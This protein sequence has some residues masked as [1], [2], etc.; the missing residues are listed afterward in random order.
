MSHGI[1]AYGSYLPRHRLGERVAAAYDEDATTMAVAAAQAAL[2]DDHRIGHVWLATTSPPYLDK[3]NAA[4][5]HAALAL[6]REVFAADVGGAARSGIAALRAGIAAGGLV[7]LADVRVGLPGSADEKTGGD[8]AAAFVFGEGESIADVVASASATIELLDRW[9][10]PDAVAARTWEE[11]FGAEALSPLV[12]ETAARALADVGLEQADHVVVVSSSAG[13]RRAAGRLLTGRF[14]TSTSPIGHAGA[15]DAGL[16][17]AAV[18]DSAGSDETILLISAADG[19]DALVF[20]TTQ[21]LLSRRQPSPVSAQLPGEPVEY[22]RYLTWRGLLDREPPRR[23]E[24][25]APAGPPAFR[26]ADWKFALTGS[27]CEKCGFT[28]LPPSRVCKQCA[29]VDHMAAVTLAGRQGRIATYTVDRL[30]YSLSPPVV[31]AVVDFDGGGRYTFEVADARP[32]D[33]EVGR[34]VSLTFRRLFTANGVH[35]YFWKVRLQ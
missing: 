2:R 18:L 17:L 27:S 24:P 31:Q 16:A 11:R 29:T 13:V 35:N 7:T 6:P 1:L 9:R 10:T 19:C 22:T 32:E 26:A 21:A 8:G 23:P 20:R 12:R 15:A 5:L 4:I 28:H 14:T 25:D 3:T 34:R 30:A 33:L